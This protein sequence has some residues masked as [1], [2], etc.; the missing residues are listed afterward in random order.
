M[1]VLMSKQNHSSSSNAA[2][3]EKEIDCEDGQRGGLA[4]S[5][6]IPQLQEILFPPSLKW[7]GFI[8]QTGPTEWKSKGNW[9]EKW[10][11]ENMATFLE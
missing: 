7:K 11:P 4:S 5:A 9:P 3:I 6:Q 1:P 8:T 2:K 10:F